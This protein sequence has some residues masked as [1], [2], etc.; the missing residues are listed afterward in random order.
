MPATAS[1]ARYRERAASRALER[2]KLS[3]LWIPSCCVRCGVCVCVHV[4][5]ACSPTRSLGVR[6]RML[7]R[8]L[9]CACPR[10]HGADCGGTAACSRFGF[11]VR[12]HE[13]T[14]DGICTARRCCAC[15]ASG[16]CNVR[17]LSFPP[18][19]LFFWRC[20]ILPRDVCIFSLGPIDDRVAQTPNTRLSVRLFQRV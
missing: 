15:S 16:S 17:R 20:V 8:G 9:F 19:P 7:C 18:F 13:D 3:L 2:R 14:L 6:K 1:V 4:P 10:V 11:V 12:Q 5:G